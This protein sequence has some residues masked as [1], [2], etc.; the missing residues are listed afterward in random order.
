MTPEAVVAEA[1]E[2]HREAETAG[3][4]VRL[5]GSLAIADRCPN[6]A[7]LMPALGRRPP[8]DID[9][10]TYASGERPLGTLLT[11]RG[12][13]LHPSLRHSREWGV[14]RLVYTHHET[15]AKVDL[16]LDQLVM[17]HTIDFTGRLEAHEFTVAP[18]DLL[19][20]KL[21]IYRI[22]RNDLIDLAVLLA[23]ADFGDDPNDINLAR[24]RAV[25]GDD[26]GF[27][28]G[29]IVNLDRLVDEVPQFSELEPEV[30]RRIDDQARR[31]RAE[32][33]QAPKSLR[34]RL[35]ARVG[36][37]APWYEHVDDVED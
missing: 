2:I 6:H 24:I 3:V 35:R 8:Q 21:Q 15:G 7:W 33:E 36:T 20:S 10:M 37:R 30:A 22:T 19:L 32:I 16:F 11:A 31:L 12:Y 29:A 4:A 17:A 23:E 9:F 18:A 13:E 27:A 1:R 5:I 34:W 25:L 26:W 28:H 14:N